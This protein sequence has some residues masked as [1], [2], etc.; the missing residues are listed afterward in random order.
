MRV[1]PQLTAVLQAL[2]VT[3]LWS[4]SWVFIKIGLQDIPALTFAG[5]R[6]FLA[7]LVL[8]PVFLLSGQRAEIK[9]LTR[10]DWGILVLLGL[11]FYTVTQGT[12]FLGLNYLPAVT[13]S[14][15]LNG[16]ALVVAILGIFILGEILSKLQWA[17]MLIFVA[18]VAVFFY[19]FDFFEGSAFGYFIAGLSVLAT[20][21]SSVIGRAVNR[22]QRFGPLTITTISMGFGSIVLLLIGWLVEEPPYLDLT[23]WLIVI[24]LAVVNTA[25]A[26]TLWNRTLRTLSA[27]ESSVINNTML[28]Q[29]SILAWLFLGESLSWLQI[30]G[31]ILAA[32]G[33]LFVQLKRKNKR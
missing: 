18:G 15:M 6:Y 19:P 26:F 22:Q 16:T 3:F 29:I 11:L 17:G 31:L 30:V 2:F 12:Q 20:S 5:L 7:F 1:S 32:V 9:S 8:L 14:L 23:G 27:T 4:T 13:F 24:W 33:T 10:K 25:F 21:L 28:I